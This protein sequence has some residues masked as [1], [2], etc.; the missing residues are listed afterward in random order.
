MLIVFILGAAVNAIN[1]I[2]S[3]IQ[4]A[5]RV[6]S[7]YWVYSVSLDILLDKAKTVN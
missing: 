3:I 4:C 5:Y 1:T 7:V 2:N 6:D